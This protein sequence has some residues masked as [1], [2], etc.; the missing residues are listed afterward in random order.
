[1]LAGGFYLVEEAP[2]YAELFVPGKEVE[3]WRTPAELVDKIRYYLSHEDERRAV[4]KAGHRRALADHTWRHRFEML[5]ED[6]N[7]R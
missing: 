7:L 1:P 6:L 3:T 4:A 2:D 5:F